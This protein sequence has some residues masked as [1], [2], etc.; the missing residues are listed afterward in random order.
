MSNESSKDR[1]GLCSFMFDDGRHCAM[2][3]VDA[4]TPYCY[5]HAKREQ[6]RLRAEE[7]GLRFARFL[8][9]DVQTACDLG[10]TFAMLFVWTASGYLSPQTANSLTRLGQLM[11]K[12]HSLAGSEFVSTWQET[13]PQVV[14]ESEA[15][16]CNAEEDDSG[17]QPHNAAPAPQPP[18]GTPAPGSP[19]PQ[20]AT[21]QHPPG[22]SSHR[23]ANGP[24]DHSANPATAQRCPG[25]P[26]R[27]SIASN[28]ASTSP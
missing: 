17:L 15:F 2:P 24:A 5:F 1:T 20:Q 6:E 12:T 23:A 22:D 14:A 19:Q 26:R 13:W 27:S 28:S 21:D 10:A 8:N 7:M 9:G 16:N 11:L 18:Q 4:K 25:S 3:Q